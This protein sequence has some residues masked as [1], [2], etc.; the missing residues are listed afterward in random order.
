MIGSYL[1]STN[2]VFLKMWAWL[3]CL[4]LFVSV[5]DITTAGRLNE[6]SGS[7]K[8][9]ISETNKDIRNLTTELLQ[10]HWKTITTTIMFC[11]SSLGV[12]HSYKTNPLHTLGEIPQ[13]V[14]TCCFHCSHRH[15]SCFPTFKKHRLR[16]PFPSVALSLPLSIAVRQEWGWGW[17]GQGG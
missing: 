16:R 1:S 13:L 11:S 12:S 7:P 4:L 15:Q 2:I 10:K 5:A 8:N 14:K 6:E 17:L 3:F 9:I